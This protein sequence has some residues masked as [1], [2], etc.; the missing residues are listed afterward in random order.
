VAKVIFPNVDSDEARN[1][2]LEWETTFAAIHDGVAVVDGEGKIRRSNSSLALLLGRPLDALT[3][4]VCHKLWGSSNVDRIPFYPVLESRRRQTVEFEYQSKHIQLS[5]D[6]IVT[7]S[8]VVSGAVYI[9]RDITET[10]QLEEQFRESQKFET[11]GT[12]AA[13]VAHDYNN[14]LTSIMG[15]ASLALNDLP[16]QHPIR[17]RLDDVVRASQR[18]ADLTKQLLA[19]SGKGRHYLQKLEVTALVRDTEKLIRAGAPKLVDLRFELGSALPPIE[20]DLHQVQQSL[21]NLV[22]NAVEAIGEASGTV[23]IRT[24][25]QDGREVFIEVVDDGCGMDSAVRERI[26]DP[27]F[28]TKFTGRGLGLSAVAGIMRGHRGRIEV[29]SASGQGST[30]RLF[31]PCVVPAPAREPA[32]VLRETATIL[33]VDD[34][35]MVRR[36]AR[37]ALEPRGH[38]ILMASNGREAIRQVQK[39]RQIDLVLLDLIM[40]VMGGEEAIDEILAANPNL[41]VIVSTGYDERETSLRF[42]QKRVAGF[43]QK[44]YTARQLTE[45]I[46]AALAGE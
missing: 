5:V 17:E 15:N 39:N 31:F 38:K 37:A 34:E 25:K 45:A 41:R 36:I 10:R 23:L 46:R 20:A 19:Y 40:P 26:F 33:V 28:T 7:N 27:F 14:L 21:I 13:G 44:P 1:L 16:E 2:A 18:A 42:A 3:G 24:G 35:D 32:E 43:L 6:P 30:F 8:G 4:E 11:I 9:V 12:L 29:N 22:T